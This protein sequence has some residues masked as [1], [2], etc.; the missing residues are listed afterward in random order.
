MINKGIP[1]PGRDYHWSVVA[2]GESWGSV[3]GDELLRLAFTYGDKCGP[4]DLVPPVPSKPENESWAMPPNEW[5]KYIDIGW[6]NAEEN[7]FPEEFEFQVATDPGFTHIVLTGKTEF[8][9]SGAKIPVPNCTHLY[10]RVRSVVGTSTS[11]WSEPNSFYYASDNNCWL[12]DSPGDTALI[13][14]FIFMD[15][16]DHT[17]PVI[18]LGEDILPPC[19]VSQYGVHADG[20]PVITD[21][22]EPG[23]EGILVELGLGPCPSTG[24]D[25]FISL[26]NGMYYFTPQ[27]PGE[28]CVS[29]SKAENPGLEK[30]HLDSAAD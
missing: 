10:W 28:Y 20:S 12:V 26:A 14:G 5:S 22:S 4:G 6:V 15:R 9:S 29:V 13:K 18:P 17:N 24:Q 19:E 7:C 2:A 1:V 27:A 30:G 16:C 23:L 21:N 3:Q 8:P 11:A 25:E